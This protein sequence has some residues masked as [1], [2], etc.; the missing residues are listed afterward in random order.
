MDPI[1]QTLLSWQFIIFGLS[2]S[3]VI[4]VIR[5]IVEYLMSQ[6]AAIAK[7][8]KLWNN[9]VLPILP[10][11][12]GGLLGLFFKMFPYPDDL[13]LKWDRVMF[14]VV[15]GLLSTFLYGVIKSLL[16]QKIGSIVPGTA[17]ADPAPEAPPAPPALEADPS[18]NT[19]K[20]AAT[21]PS[22]DQ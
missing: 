22:V 14:G 21:G 5:T 18:T 3:A 7:E 17:A 13:T 11:I 8:S 4:F 15:A 2:I 19:A 9:L 16:Q 12:L 6:Y 20:P 10:I 1:L